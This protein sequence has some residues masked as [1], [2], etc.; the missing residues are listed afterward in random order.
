MKPKSRQLT[1]S[2][3]LVVAA[4]L[5][6]CAAPAVTPSAAPIPPAATSIP[7]EPTSV[8]PTA[9][10]TPVAPAPDTPVATEPQPPREGLLPDAPE[11]ARHGPF[12]VGFK[13]LVIGQGSDRPLEAGIWYPALNPS[14]AKEEIAYTVTLKFLVGQISSPVVANGHALMDAA[15]DARAAPYP[16]VI[17][18]HGFAANAVWYNTLLEHYASHGFIVLAPEHADRWDPEKSEAWK[19]TIDRPPDIKRTLDYAAQI[20][21]PGGDMA[22]QIDMQRVAVIGQSAGGEAALAMGGAQYDLA[23]FNARCAQLPHN[24][25]HASL[26]APVLPNEKDM[27]AR[28]GL[29]PMPEGLWPSFGDPRVTAI[30]SI[31][32]DSYLYGEAGLAKITVPMMAIG[33]TGDTATPYEWGSKPSYDDASSAKKALVTLVGAEHTIANS[34]CKSMTWWRQTP[35]YQWICFDP[36][37]DKERGL[38]LINHFSTAFLLDTLKSDAAAAAALAP[39]NVSFAGI[40]YETIGWQ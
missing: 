38:D 26:C 7:P 3:V 23:A 11:Y 8:P 28:A 35:F 6:A 19:A 40:K 10:P 37:W 34:G 27:A 30:I 9:S 13:S 14:G 18:S 24:D 16:L 25:P 12:W 29:D 21:A 32:G 20:A 1:A 39:K 2:C 33:G 36:A 22:G 15:V 31:A 5:V 17:F 4:L